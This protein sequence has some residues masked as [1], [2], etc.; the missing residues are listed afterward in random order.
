MDRW[1]ITLG[2]ALG[3]LV[4]GA[5]ACGSAQPRAAAVRAAE[6]STGE[7]SATLVRTGSNLNP[8]PAPRGT[9]IIGRGPEG[10]FWV[11]ALSAESAE[12]FAGESTP[13]ADGWRRTLV[14]G[15]D[16]L[17][18]AHDA[19]H[20]LI[21]GHAGGDPA[22]V[23]AAAFDLGHLPDGWRFA[24]ISPEAETGAIYDPEADPPE[25][26]TVG[27]SQ[28]RIDL[29]DGSAR[30]ALVVAAGPDALSG[31][32]QRYGA[33]G[34]HAFTGEFIEGEPVLALGWPDGNRT[35][36]ILRPGE[37]EDLL[38]RSDD[39]LALAGEVAS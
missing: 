24:A 25:S 33:R 28:V 8:E 15:V 27:T 7:L 10:R 22:T 29:G 9:L 39:L 35:L 16:Q 2:V 11:Q 34:P 20:R 36:I 6:A 5:G 32:V 1:R 4:M 12:A 21:T 3:S 23:G 37:V 13:V 18:L 26:L 30:D 38:D 14:P 31:M 17:V 19:E